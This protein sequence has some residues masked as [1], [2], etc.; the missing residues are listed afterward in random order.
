[1]RCYP[2]LEKLTAAAN[3]LKSM[4]YPLGVNLTTLSQV[5]ISDENFDAT[6][7]GANTRELYHNPLRATR[8]A[9]LEGDGLATQAKH[10]LTTHEHSHD[11]RRAW[12][13]VLHFQ[14]H[15]MVT[16]L[17]LSLISRHIAWFST[18]PICSHTREHL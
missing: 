10:Y 1:M 5:V 12:V 8:H 15:S 11:D 3:Q 9:H 14:L 13:C 2:L 17:D 4:T 18:L 7:T 6:T 16:A